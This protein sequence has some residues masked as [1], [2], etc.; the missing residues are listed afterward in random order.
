MLSVYI[1]EDNQAFLA[2][3]K[4]IIENFILIHDLDISL[5]LATKTPHDILS[6][7]EDKFCPGIYFLDVD[8]QDKI[9]GIELAASIRKKDPRGFIIFVTT[10]EEAT[11][12]IFKFKVEAMDYIL[13]DDMDALPDRIFSCICNA[14]EKYSSSE[15]KIHK[16]M[17]IKIGSQRKYIPHQDVIS[18]HASDIPHKSIIYTANGMFEIKRTLKE[19]EQDLGQ[20]FE[21][22]HKS[23]IVN[24]MYIVE[25]NAR[26]RTLLTSDGNVCPVSQRKISNFLK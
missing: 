2:H 17:E 22:C 20:P 7:I 24:P 25:I 26:Q 9:N 11:P 4:K 3:M 12:L 5:V 1:C 19:I 18:I 16:N 23:C 21:R 14:L 13:K 8:L 10:H 6:K 15:N